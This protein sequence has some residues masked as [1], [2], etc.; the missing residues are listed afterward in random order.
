MHYDEKY[1]NKPFEYMPERWLDTEDKQ[2]RHAYAYA[3]FGG[4]ARVCIGNNFSLLEQKLFLATLLR[5]YSV[6]LPEEN[7][8]CPID[9]KGVYAPNK[10]LKLI[11]KKRV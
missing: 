6:H 4:G 3:P 10:N 5:E 2:P 9:F 8:K 7:Y 1:W 11:F